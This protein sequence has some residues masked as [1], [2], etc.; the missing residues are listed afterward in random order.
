V[1]ADKAGR[2]LLQKHIPAKHSMPSCDVTHYVDVTQTTKQ[3]IYRS[4]QI[5]NKQACEQNKRHLT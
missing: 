4:A 2:L 1:W 3:R 5:D